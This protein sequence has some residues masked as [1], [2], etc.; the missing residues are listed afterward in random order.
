MFFWLWNVTVKKI[1]R[2]GKNSQEDKQDSVVEIY[3]SSCIKLYHK[4]ILQK[5]AGKSYNGITADKVRCVTSLK[6]KLDRET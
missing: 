3:C 4:F 2:T 1:S 6:W 5:R